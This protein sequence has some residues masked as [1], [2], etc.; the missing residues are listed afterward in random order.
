MVGGLMR[1][2][3]GKRSQFRNFAGCPAVGGVGANAC[4]R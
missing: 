3:G 4:G 2:A 1:R